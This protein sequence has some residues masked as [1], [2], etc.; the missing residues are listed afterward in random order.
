M[1]IFTNVTRE[2]QGGI[3]SANNSL[4]SFLTA[5][6]QRIVGLEFDTV[7]C[8]KGPIFI[9]E[10]DR[11]FFEHY[12]MTMHDL[13][14][15]NI[16]RSARNLRDMRTYFSP[17]IF[18]IK[19]VIKSTK[20]DIVLLNGTSYFPWLIS[21]AAYECGMPIVLRYHGITARETVHLP[22]GP[23]RLFLR[24]EQSYRYRVKAFIFP[25]TLCKK[26]VERDVY[27]KKI[28]DASII[29]N[30]VSVVSV[31]REKKPGR[32]IAVVSR[33]SWIK[34]LDAFLKLH[35]LLN[36][37]DWKHSAFLVSELKSYTKLPKTISLI[38][39]LGQ[40]ALFR[41]YAKQDLILLPSHFE[42]FGNVPMEALC[43][44][45]PV[46]V[47][48]QTGC[49]EILGAIGLED[50]IVDFSDLK[51]VAVRVKQVCGKS[52]SA[53]HMR[54]LR[55]IL[56]PKTINGKIFSVLKKTVYSSR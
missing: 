44:G 17:V 39:P 15:E 7:R 20:P 23:R 35:A 26:V 28:P 36:K 9:P 16:I 56:Y 41:F 12:Y 49:A 38:A 54:D 14:L 8:R 46:L 5:S 6:R 42:T 37:Q 19:K 55:Q 43:V 3:T 50:M 21:I 31:N 1:K 29:Y 45:V 11:R 53:R 52:I 32:N 22:L 10:L 2:Y 51:A 48:T 30:P 4:L 47:H 40:N 24:M 18:E 27:G 34:N 25:S 33:D 13:P